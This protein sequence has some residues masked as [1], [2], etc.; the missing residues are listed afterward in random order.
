[1]L[2]Y[3]RHGASGEDVLVVVNFASTAYTE[4]DVGVPDANAWRV[5]VNTDLPAYGSDFTGTESG[6]VTPVLRAKDGKPYTLPLALGAYSA[7]VLTR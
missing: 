1:M 4:Y 3:R 6:S 2:A 5:R 7:I